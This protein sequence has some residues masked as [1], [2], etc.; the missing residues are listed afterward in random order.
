MK[1]K[2]TVL[3]SV[4]MTLSFSQNPKSI[5]LL[6][7]YL[8]IGNGDVIE[9][10]LVG[11]RDNKIDVVLN[12]L[13][14]SYK[15][16]EWDTII[17]LE[18]KHIYPGFIATNSTLGL[19]EI[20]AVRATRDFNEVGAFNPHVRTQIAYNVE[21]KVI[22][23][24]RTNGVLFSQATPRGGE[25]S[26]TSSVMAMDGW[27]WEDATILADD[28]I[29]VNWPSSAV[30]YSE[31]GKDLTKNDGYVAAKKV[32]Y[33]FFE[34]SK[35]YSKGEN[36]KIDLRLEA[37]IDCFKGN[38]R[39]YLHA[40]DLQQLNDII[41]FAKHFELNFPVI[42]GGYDSYLITRL[43]KDAKIPVMLGRT[44]SLPRNEEDPVD[45]PYRI[46]ALLQEGGVL[47]CLQNEG[48][49]EAMN[50]RNLP[51][52]A[53]TAMAYGLTEEQAIQSIS[54]NACKIMGIDKE[55]GTLEVG[56]S[57]TLFVSEGN[58]LDMRTNQ[59]TLAL[60]RGQ[61]M[62]LDNSQKEL[63]SKYQKKYKK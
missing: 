45:L 4:L 47:F 23:T 53:G 58:A 49:M 7:G 20:D 50:A 61:F 59:I 41:D 10:A 35:A 30:N 5:L 18:G 52:Q 21:S 37:M 44:H 11:I 39:V 9:S 3:F 1:L 8:H 32:I 25:I 17:D 54:L 26:G 28:G 60:I 12:S 2:L 34:L 36:D 16:E 29:H 31:P 57:A 15:K 6:N 48:D 19:T 55:Y 38:K 63:Y 62:S 51:F 14:T 43:L 13:A 24:V 56:K 40:D 27:N 42:V 22:S 33:D 46:P